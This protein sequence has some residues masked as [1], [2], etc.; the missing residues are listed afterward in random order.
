MS[1][2]GLK[3]SVQVGLLVEEVTSG[4]ASGERASDG[5][6][7]LRMNNVVVGGGLDW[8]EVCRIPA[9][10]EQLAAY[11]LRSGDVLFNSTNSPKLV[12][13]TALFIEIGEPVVFSN[14]FL[15]IRTKR[16]GL[17]PAY[18]ARWLNYQQGRRLFETRC[19]Q[20]VN[21][22]SFR[23]EDL[24]ALRIPLPPLPEQR[25]IAAILD[26]ADSI[27]RKQQQAIRLA[28]DL[29]RSAF[30][31]MFGDP[32]IN[33]KGWPACR[34]AEVAAIVSGVTKGRKLDRGRIVSVPYMRVANVQ[35]GH[36]VLDDV[37]E[38]EALPEEVTRYCLEP[39]DVLLT[40][41]G[42]P[43]KLGRGAVWR[44]QVDPCIHQNHIFRVRPNKT[45]VLP[46]FLS[47]QIGSAR[48]KRY[49]LR[50]AKQ[51]TGIASINMTQLSAFPVLLPPLDA[52]ER[53]GRLTRGSEALKAR[54]E[55]R[56]S[57][58]GDLFHSLVQRAFQGDL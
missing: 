36:L 42:D 4:F 1:A 46:E 3:G 38:I 35:D 15:R 17:D 21:Q 20:W 32:V 23:R 13:K 14:H 34:L 50:A 40:E 55:V 43:D 47:R 26:K 33:P 22:A 5:T 8:S 28:D 49:F 54:M 24:L 7:Q 57:T 51:T 41:G 2:G 30:L 53:F 56:A 45:K 11:R 44:G 18:L 19:T 39:G 10:V 37:K 16:D 27:R 58:V 6:A 12:G 31:D 9:G 29:L 25:R 52:Q 48:G